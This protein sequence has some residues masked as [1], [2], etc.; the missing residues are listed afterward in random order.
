M[1][2]VFTVTS[3]GLEEDLS[4][5]QPKLLVGMRIEVS[6]DMAVSF[7]SQTGILTV[8]P[9]EEVSESVPV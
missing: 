4:V 3:Q 6:K 1:T 2:R 5:P 7:S 8:G 9:S